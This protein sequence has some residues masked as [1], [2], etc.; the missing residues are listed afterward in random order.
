MSRKRM[1]IFYLVVIAIMVS[2]S[3]IGYSALSQSLRITGDVAYH[4]KNQKLYDVL[5]D[6][7][8][9]GTYATTYN[10]SHQ[11]SINGAGNKAIYHWNNVNQKN[12]NNVIF[13]GFCWQ[14]IRTTDTGGVKMIYNGVPDE[15]KCTATGTGQQIGTSKFNESSNSLAYVGYM[16]NNVYVTESGEADSG[17][18]FGNGVTYS[19]GMYTLTDTQTSIDSTHHYTCNNTSGT[20]STVRYYYYTISW[21]SS[22]YHS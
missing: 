10:G 3:S 12:L 4:Y 11:D 13:A 19:E 7:A 2:F 22:S 15:G 20:C 21:T 14:M 8:E 17:S 6:A 16:Y 1:N 9:V 5:K 18:L